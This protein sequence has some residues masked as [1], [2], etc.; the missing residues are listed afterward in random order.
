MRDTLLN[1]EKVTLEALEFWIDNKEEGDAMPSSL[2]AYLE[3]LDLIRG[4]VHSGKS[5]GSTRLRL[6]TMFPEMSETTARERF[7]DAIYFFHLNNDLRKEGYSAIAAEKQMQ[8]AEATILSATEPSHYE[9]ASRI[10]ERAEAAYLRSKPEESQVPM[11]LL[12]KK[13]AIYS[14]KAKDVGIPE[15]NRRQLHQEIE[16]LKIEESA[17]LKLQEDL[18]SAPRQVFNYEEKHEQEES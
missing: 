9:I 15:I 14:L 4:W 5:P 1:N 6:R 7:N 8:L 18:G 17:K 13:Y 3:Q 16:Q 2:A 11:E 10:Y 12:K